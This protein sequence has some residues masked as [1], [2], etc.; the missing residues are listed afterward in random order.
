MSDDQLN[1]PLALADE[2]KPQAEV[3]PQVSSFTVLLLQILSLVCVF[4]FSGIIFGWQSLLLVLQRHGT[5]HELCD[6]SAPLDEICTEQKA[7][8]N[9]IFTIG[10][11][12]LSVS[13]QSQR[14]NYSTAVFVTPLHNWSSLSSAVLLFSKTTRG[15]RS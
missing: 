13:E 5:Y 10:S 14:A 9:L 3:A 15:S 12:T 1:T 6:Q 8:L 11:T 4:L 2:V 7:A